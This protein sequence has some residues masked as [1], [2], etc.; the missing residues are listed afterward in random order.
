MGSY[1][2]IEDNFSFLVDKD[3]LNDISVC[4][5]YGNGDILSRI[6]INAMAGINNLTEVIK[7]LNT[8]NIS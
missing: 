6:G 8:F 2:F 1:I 7:Q 4:M 3:T 5:P